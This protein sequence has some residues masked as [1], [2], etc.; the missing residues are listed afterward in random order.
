MAIN[1][2]SRTAKKIDTASK[3]P[4]LPTEKD[5]IDKYAD[6]PVCKNEKH[7]LPILSNQKGFVLLLFPHYTVF[8]CLINVWYNEN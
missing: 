5:I 8:F 2:Y 7:L 6:Y 4:L 3:I 1:G